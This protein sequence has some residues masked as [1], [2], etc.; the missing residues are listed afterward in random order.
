ML[1]FKKFVFNP[2]GVNTYL[3]FDETREA[4]II[5]AANS[6][7]SEHQE[8]LDFVKQNDLRIKYLLNTHC[9]VDHMMGNALCKKEFGADFLAHKEEIPLIERAVEMGAAFGISV[10]KPEHPDG[11]IEDGQEIKFGDTVLKAF[12]VPGHSP[13][14]LAYYIP[15]EKLLFAGDVIF[16]GSIGRTD[17]PGGD[18]DTLISSIRNKILSLDEEVVIYSGHGEKTSV[19]QEIKTN[20]FLA[21]DDE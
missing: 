5:D 17:L 2:F 7:A 10:E 15:E 14:S 1:S 20:P 19:A 12:H 13:G 11:F 6:S 9:H 21:R 4:I 3:L 8:L 18:F 16:R